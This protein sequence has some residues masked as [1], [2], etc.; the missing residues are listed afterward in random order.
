MIA[1]SE[2]KRNKGMI[3]FWVDDKKKPYILDINKGELLGLRGGALQSIP[4]CG[5]SNGK[6]E[7]E[8]CTE[9]CYAVSP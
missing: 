2:I 5:A 9:R 3:E 8:Y 6:A 1:M 7:F 4:L